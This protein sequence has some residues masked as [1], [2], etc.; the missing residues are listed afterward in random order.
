MDESLEKRILQLHSVE[1]LSMRQIARQLEISRDRVPKVIRKEGGVI[2]AKRESKLDAYQSLIGQW[3]KEYPAL[4]ARQIYE[5]LRSY[6][7]KGSYGLVV[8]YTRELRRPKKAV[9]HNLEFLPGQEAQIDWF[10]VTMP[11]GKV[12]GFLFVLSYSRFAWGKFY[13]R[14][15]FEFFLAGHMECFKKTGGVPHT[16][17][18]DNIKSVVISRTPQLQYN[19]QFLD[20]S[21]FYGFSIY[22]CNTYA[23]HEKGR[24]ERIVRDI[25]SFLYGQTFADLEDLNARFQLQLDRR[26]DTIHRATVKKPKDLLKEEKLLALP[27]ADYQIG[28]II[29]ALVSK[30]GL[31][32]FDTNK[33]SVPNSYSSRPVQLIA[34]PDKIIVMLGPHQ[35]A[36]HKRSFLKNQVIENPLHRERLLETTPKYKYQRILQLMKKLDPIIDLF[37]TRAEESGEEQIYYAYQLFKLL[38][39]SSKAMLISAVREAC[40]IKAFKLKTIFSLLKLP[41]EKEHRPVY[42]KDNKLLDIQYPERRLED[43]DQLD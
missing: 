35:I 10:I 29:P 24:V 39:F 20:F 2:T 19:P 43:Y 23:A 8:A 42:P 40:S 26:N 13:L 9:Y 7:F 32:Q 12:Y 15:S 14:N 31:V 22:V 18:Y 30:T 1:K 16:L 28:K 27:R 3:Y 11:F 41:S 37:L 4:M 5:R 6:G 17:R 36:A 38:K 21:R 25:R 34:Y 33:Y